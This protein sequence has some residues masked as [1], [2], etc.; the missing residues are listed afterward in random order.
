MQKWLRSFS[1]CLIGCFW[2]CLRFQQFL[3][4][5]LILV[6]TSRKIFPMALPKPER[7]KRKVGSGVLVCFMLCNS[8]EMCFRSCVIR[9]RVSLCDECCVCIVVLVVWVCASVVSM[10]DCMT[11]IAKL[12][13]IQKILSVRY[14]IYAIFK[15]HANQIQEKKM[16]GKVQ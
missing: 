12:S 10:T 14:I 6:T 4:C 15:L 11:K 13:R 9:V 3:V 2:N 7:L 16:F 8:F 5:V 1:C